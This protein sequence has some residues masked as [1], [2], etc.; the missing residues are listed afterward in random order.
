M[1]RTRIRTSV[2]ILAATVGVAVV[3]A[4]ANALSSRGSFAPGTGG[5]LTKPTNVSSAR[6]VNGT[7]NPKCE[8][9]TAAANSWE[10]AGAAADLEGNIE[11]ANKDYNYADAIA[12][13]ANAGPNDCIIYQTL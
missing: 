9:A 4:T 5:G 3:P 2:A 12:G 13:Q 11:E 8:A 1:L 7:G 10:S 6:Y